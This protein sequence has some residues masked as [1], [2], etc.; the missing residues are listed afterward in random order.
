MHRLLPALLALVLPMAALAS[1]TA[2][3]GRALAAAHCAGCHAIGPTDASRHPAAPPLRVLHRRYP[4][5]HLAE[6]LAEGVVTGHPAMPEF[7][8]IPAEIEALIAYLQTLE[9]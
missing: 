5:E 2:E 1:P 7:R 6:A 4:V 9:R 8:F 3:R